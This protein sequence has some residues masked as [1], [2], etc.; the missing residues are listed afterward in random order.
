MC[1]VFKLFALVQYFFCVSQY[2]YLITQFFFA[3]IRALC[4]IIIIVLLCSNLISSW[5]CPLFSDVGVVAPPL[6]TL[7]GLAAGLSIP[8]TS[9]CPVQPHH[10]A[11]YTNRW[12]SFLQYL[13]TWRKILQCWLYLHTCF[14]QIN[15]HS[16]LA[17]VLC[18]D[19]ALKG[20]A[21]K[22]EL[23]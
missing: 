1:L 17:I 19:F 3:F 9:C 4:Y 22:T 18:I 16:I 14:L 11:S 23:A 5:M 13:Y 15:H 2:R 21:H 7:L 6:S 10:T 20:Q 8:G 12:A